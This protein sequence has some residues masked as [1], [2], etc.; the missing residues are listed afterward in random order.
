[1]LERKSFTLCLFFLLLVFDTQ[2]NPTNPTWQTTSLIQ[3]GIY[4]LK[5]RSGYYSKRVNLSARQ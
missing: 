5:D 4:I 3:A 1:M 2:S